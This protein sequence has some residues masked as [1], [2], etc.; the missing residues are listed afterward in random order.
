M[1][2]RTKDKPTG[3]FG[4]SAEGAIEVSNR[5]LAL[6]EDVEVTSASEVAVQIANRILQA[7][8]IDDVLGMA[9]SAGTGARDIV[10]RP[11]TIMALPVWRKA[12]EAYKEGSGFFVVLQLGMKDTN[13]VI[14]VTTGAAN[15]LAQLYTMQTK[16]MLPNDIVMQFTEKSA[17]SGNEVLWLAKYAQ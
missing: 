9:D 3:T 17:N 4:D 12:K 6:T 15:V 11:F 5:Y 14:P 7:E 16:G 2:P 1:A 8:S 13:E 10:G